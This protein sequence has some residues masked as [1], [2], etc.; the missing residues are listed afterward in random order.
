MQKISLLAITMS[1]LFRINVQHTVI[2]GYH[3]FK[4][5]PPKTLSV[6]IDT[7]FTHIHIKNAASMDASIQ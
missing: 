1:K 2:K 4:I 3:Y 7:M 5:N 6:E